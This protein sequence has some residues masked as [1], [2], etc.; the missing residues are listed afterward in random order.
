[1]TTY[2]QSRSRTAPAASNSFS[3]WRKNSPVVV[4]IRSVLIDSIGTSGNTA[5]ALKTSPNAS[6]LGRLL[7]KRKFGEF[8]R[9]APPTC[10]RR[11]QSVI[12]LAS[13][14]FCATLAQ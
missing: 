9:S 2:F 14:A 12:F 5:A 7:M 13:M 8:G 6:T 10:S 11:A 3:S 1:M 4:D